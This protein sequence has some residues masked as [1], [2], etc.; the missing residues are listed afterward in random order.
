MVHLT[1]PMSHGLFHRAI[2]QSP[3]IPTAREKVLPLTELAD[4]EKT[5]VE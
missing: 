4:A 5:A 3:G 2:L 1:S